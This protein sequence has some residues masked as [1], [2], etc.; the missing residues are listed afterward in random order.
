V[1][2][3]AYGD[4]ISDSYLRHLNDDQ[5]DKEGSFDGIVS[6]LFQ[7]FY[8]KDTNV[9][10]QRSLILFCWPVTGDKTS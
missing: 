1:S 2:C 7:W 5:P 8:Y 6:E 3:C 9:S 10:M 4:E